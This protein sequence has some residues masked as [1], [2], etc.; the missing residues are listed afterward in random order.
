MVWP[1]R[2]SVRR[3]PDPQ[4]QRSGIRAD[5]TGPMPPLFPLR[6]RDATNFCPCESTL[7]PDREGGRGD[8]DKLAGSPFTGPGEKPRECR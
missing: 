6:G 3:P 5:P 1:T 7:K 8:F 2:R 4:Q